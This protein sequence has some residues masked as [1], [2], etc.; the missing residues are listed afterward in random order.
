M[1]VILD[2]IYKFVG[3][4]GIH[5]LALCIFLFT[6]VVKMLMLPLTIKQQK[7]TRLSSKMN[8]ELTKIQEKY[9]GKK[10]KSQ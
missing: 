1:G 3:L 9:K 10:T 7:F 8:P 6:F 2:A 4:F 5:N